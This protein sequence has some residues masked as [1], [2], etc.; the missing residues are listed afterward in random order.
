MG[1]GFYGKG[2]SELSGFEYHIFH[3]TCNRIRQNL[4]LFMYFFFGGGGGGCGLAG[5]I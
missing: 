1:P 5:S 4:Q 2:G 3:Q